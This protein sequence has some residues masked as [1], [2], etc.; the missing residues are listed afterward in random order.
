MILDTICVGTFQVN[1]YI[2]SMGDNRQAIIIDPGG[3]KNKI[4]EALD[5]HKLR[6]AFIINTHGHIDHIGLD[7]EFAVPIYIHRAEVP[8]LG[9]SGLNLS[10]FLNVPYS[11]KSP[12]KVLDDKSKIVL[13]EIELEVI[14]TPGHT[15]GGICL[16]LKK[17]VNNIL[18]SGDTLF[19]ES[20]GRT[21]FAGASA[22]ILMKSIKEKLLLLPDDTV[23]Y[24]GHGR[25][26]TI[27]H[28]KKYNPFLT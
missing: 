16:L 28:E 21:D 15:K 11:V 13:D 5:K 17:P 27:G 3:Q 6:P 19:Y 23:I 26:S 25:S 1:C 4:K 8:M 2:L 20:V 14:H 12:I 7:D 22:T 24:P 10:D 18:F 9:N